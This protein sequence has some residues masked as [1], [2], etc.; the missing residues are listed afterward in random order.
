MSTNIYMIERNVPFIYNVISMVIIMI[1]STIDITVI[2]TSC[3]ENIN[4]L[5]TYHAKMDILLL[6]NRIW[7]FLARLWWMVLWVLAG[8]EKVQEC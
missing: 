7:G 8:V 6:Q 4:T 1:I 5:N 2:C 3:F